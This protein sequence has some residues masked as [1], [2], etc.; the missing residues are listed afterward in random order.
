MPWSLLRQK[1]PHQWATNDLPV[2]TRPEAGLSLQPSGADPG[3][4]ATGAKLA[5]KRGIAQ[6]SRILRPPGEVGGSGDGDAFIAVVPRGSCFVEGP[7]VAGAARGTACSFAEPGVLERVW[8]GFPLED[9]A[10]P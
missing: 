7:S 5:S 1:R 6:H 2:G 9:G 4:T 3:L 10:A 8:R